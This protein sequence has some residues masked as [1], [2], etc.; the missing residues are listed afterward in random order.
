MILTKQRVESIEPGA[1]DVFA[2]DDR[3]AGFGVRVKPSG[4]R[5]YVIQYRNSQGRS[6]RMTVGRHGVLTPDEARTR[7][8]KLLAKVTD[9]N[10]PAGDRATYRKAP[11]V[12]ELCDRYL[13]EHVAEHNKPSTEKEFRRLVEKRIKPA[14]GHLKAVDVTRQDVITLHLAMRSTPRQANHTVAVLSKLFN[15]AELWGVRPDGSNPCRHV[16]R[17]AETMRERFLS[18]RELSRLGEALAEAEASTSERPGVIAAIR[19]LALSGCRLGEILGLRWE[20]VDLETGAL[21]IRDAKAGDRVQTIG[22]P[23]LALLDTL[24]RAGEWVV[25]STSPKRPIPVSTIENAWA[26]LRVQAGLA[27][28][29]LH[30]L[31]HTVATRLFVVDRWTPGEVQQYLGHRDPRVTLRIYTHVAAE[32]LLADRPRKSRMFGVIVTRRYPPF[33]AR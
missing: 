1:R 25:F 21:C 27:D 22:G 3:L 17:Y 15:L 7:A 5:S 6:R 30:D 9:G 13:T 23:A 31:R 29:R 32:A 16:K 33:L 2:W 24:P 4:T 20:D 19:L 18:D 11:T 26:R 28:V 10:D 12:A 14:L 8:K